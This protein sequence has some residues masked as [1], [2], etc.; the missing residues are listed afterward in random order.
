MEPH[1]FF[2]FVNITYLEAPKKISFY[3]SKTWV[4][5]DCQKL[6]G[7][8]GKSHDAVFTES[9]CQLQKIEPIVQHRYDS[10]WPK[11]LEPVS[12]QRNVNALTGKQS[13][14]KTSLFCMLSQLPRGDR[15][16]AHIQF[17]MSKW[18]T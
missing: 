7:K 16:V 1:F 8:K 17:P 10:A 14:K 4:R 12:V 18:A 3:I 15:E 13:L 2:N 11:C 6:R 9:M 5:Y